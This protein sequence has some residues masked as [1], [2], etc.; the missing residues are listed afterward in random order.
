MA[1]KAAKRYRPKNDTVLKNVI[2]RCDKRGSFDSLKLP[3][4]SNTEYAI[5]RVQLQSFKKS[6]RGTIHTE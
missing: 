1:L 6:S 5:M 4:E 2:L 3:G